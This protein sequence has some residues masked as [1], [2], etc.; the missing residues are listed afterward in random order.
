M[1]RT[2]RILALACVPLVVTGT[3]EAQVVADHNSVALFEQ[4]PGE[5]LS[6]AANLRMMFVDQSVGGNISEG[7]TCL[8]YESDT[9]APSSCKSYTHVV[10]EFSS[11]PSEVTW[12]H[13]G[14]YNRSNWTYYGWPGN[15]IPPELPCASG[16]DG[17]WS[18][19]VECFIEYV[20]ANPS[21]YDVYGFQL[22]YLQV[23]PG[24]NIAS[25]TTG[26]FVPQTRAFDVADV[27]ALEARHPNR[28]FI[29]NTTSLARSIGDEEAT[30]F[31][32]QM[33]AYVR[34]HGGYL[35]DVAD[36]ESHDPWGQ[37]CY[38]NRDGVPY[39]VNGVVMENHPDDG[40]NLPAVCPQYT[41]EAEG[42]HLGNPDVGKIR[43]A[44][45]FWVLMARIA[46]WSPAGSTGAPAAPA[47]LRII[48]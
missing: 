27:E 33:R 19:Y 37:P 20:D 31:N 23:M 18:G 2:L 41:R 4:I 29:N 3:A 22:S 1:Q 39:I 26:Y 14:G 48:R 25:T 21:A 38:D 7:L 42:G 13:P 32:D 6:A 17:S 12:S 15:G 30:D 8:G 35:L 44:K 24:T 10:P 11:P 34:A 46:G 36:I 16:A 47:N 5:Y 40:L 43:L 28:V 45:A 9:V